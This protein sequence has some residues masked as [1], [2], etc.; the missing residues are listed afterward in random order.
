MFNYHIKIMVNQYKDDEFINSLQSL[1]PNIRK[2]HK[3]EGCHFYR[4]LNEKHV[5]IVTGEWKSLKAM[6]KHFHSSNFEILIGACRVLGK[7]FKLKIGEYFKTGGLSLPRE[8][9][10]GK[11]SFKRNHNIY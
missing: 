11:Q 3:C 6:D 9:I 4:D 8:L 5:Y 7:E 2:E 1:L 10:S